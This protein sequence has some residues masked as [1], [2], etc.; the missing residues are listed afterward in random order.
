[1]NLVLKTSILEELQL[2]HVSVDWFTFSTS[3]GDPGKRIRYHQK[4]R[5]S[6]EEFSNKSEFLVSM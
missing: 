6:Q 2:L 3:V 5:I 4:I 1:M